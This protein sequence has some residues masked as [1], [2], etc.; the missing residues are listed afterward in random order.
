MG[1]NVG[2]GSAEEVSVPKFLHFPF[3]CPFLHPFGVVA[4]VH[5]QLS[6]VTTSSHLGSLP[7]PGKALPKLSLSFG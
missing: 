7:Y 4:A 5:L 6:L 1:R 3:L 2:E